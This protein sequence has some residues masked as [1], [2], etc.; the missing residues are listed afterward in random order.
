MVVLLFLLLLVT[1]LAAERMSPKSCFAF[2]MRSVSCVVHRAL[3]V[4][5]RAPR[6]NVTNLLV[7]RFQFSV[8]KREMGIVSLVVTDNADSLW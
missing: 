7:F 6:L 3:C 5:S 1:L 4:D 2:L 8:V